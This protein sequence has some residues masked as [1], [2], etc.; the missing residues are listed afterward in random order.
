METIRLQD[1]FTKNYGDSLETRKVTITGM[2]W[3]T[4]GLM[5]Y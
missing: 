3:I 1:F 2:D 4:L 5:N